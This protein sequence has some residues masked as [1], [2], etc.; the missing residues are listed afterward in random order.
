MSSSSS[1]RPFYLPHNN[2]PHKAV[3][4]QRVTNQLTFQVLM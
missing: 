3:T 4:T 2:V 1:S